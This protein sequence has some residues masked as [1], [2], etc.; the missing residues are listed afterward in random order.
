MQS[1]RDGL[2]SQAG[3]GNEDVKDLS[4]HIDVPIQTEDQ[5]L[6]AVG[7]DDL[8]GPV[9]QSRRQ[10]PVHGL[11]DELAADGLGNVVVHARVQTGLAILLGGMGRHGDDRH[12]L[13]PS[14]GLA[15]TDHVRGF[16]ST[17]NRHLDVHEHQIKIPFRKELQGFLAVGRTLGAKAQLV[18]HAHGYGLIHHVVL[19]QENAQVLGPL[20]PLLGFAGRLFTLDPD[21][22]GFVRLGKENREPEGRTFVLPA[23]DAHA[24]AHLFHQLAG[25]VQA[26]AR[27][28]VLARGRGISLGEGFEKFAL[29]LGGDA[30]ARVGNFE[31]HPLRRE[32]AFA[33]GVARYLQA[34]RAFFGELQRVAHQVDQ[35]LMQPRLVADDEFGQ[36]IIQVQNKLQ[37][38]LADLENKGVGHALDRVG[39]VEGFVFE[40]QLAGLDLGKIQNL[41]D[42]P[43]QTARAGSHDFRG[44]PLLVAQLHVQQQIGHADDR[45]QGRAQFVG[46]VGD[47]RALGGIG[48]RRPPGPGG[49]P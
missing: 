41:I 34:D 2:Q 21:D 37:A 30:D 6:H 24:S 42:D 19:D 15:F 23:F 10:G 1:A 38:F 7:F 39:Q 14:A 33:V 36:L 46:Q 25:D 12:V 20:F 27:A 3:V 28:A 4:G 5:F 17:Q 31:P 16:D 22:L 13:V 45:V 8:F 47:E 11:G 44:L 43:E 9:Q 48:L 26:Q 35:N 49:G 40:L 32:L 29:G 18:Q